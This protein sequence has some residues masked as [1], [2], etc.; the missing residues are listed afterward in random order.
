METQNHNEP[1][2]RRRGFGSSTLIFGI[3]VI[4]AGL[5]MLLSNTGLLPHNWHHNI[6][7][8]GMLIVVIGLVN[9]IGRKWW[10]GLLLVIAGIFLMPDV[11]HNVFSEDV[12]FWHV[13]WPAVIILFG[14]GMIFGTGHMFRHRRID[15][16]SSGD[17]YIDEVA[18]FGGGD[19][20]VHSEAFKGGR[21]V[22]VFGGSKIDLTN[23]KMAPGVNEL[24]MIVVFGGSELVIPADWN[25][26][27][28]VFSI[29]GGYS[30]KRG[31]TQVDYSK[32]LII[33]GV[34][35]FGGGEI[36]RK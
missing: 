17:D 6:F 33:K 13:F 20:V 9:I 15:T 24:E 28:E 10:W 7:S 31:P 16:I 29:F 26:K 32:T 27:I 11:F 5:V 8:W 2:C 3:V 14:L 12:N 25:I 34:T 4:L 19:R 1:C 18:V 30:D 23:T 21:M 35:I 36:K 22:A